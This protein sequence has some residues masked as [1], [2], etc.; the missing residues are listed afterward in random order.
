[1]NSLIKYKIKKSK[2]FGKCQDSPFMCTV[3]Y[4]KLWGVFWSI[5]ILNPWFGFWTAL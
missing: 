3:V 4:I 5:F 1:M 2:T